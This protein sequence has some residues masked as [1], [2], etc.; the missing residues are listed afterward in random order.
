MLRTQDIYWW[1]NFTWKISLTITIKY[2]TINNYNF[3]KIQSHDKKNSNFITFYKYYIGS[4]GILVAKLKKW[5]RKLAEIAL[6]A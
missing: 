1:F 2:N 4:L 6:R 3:H 5:W